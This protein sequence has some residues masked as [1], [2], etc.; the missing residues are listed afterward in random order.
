MMNGLANVSRFESQSTSL[1]RRTFLRIAG[2]GSVALAVFGVA[3]CSGLAQVT[4]T[5][6]GTT[7]STAAAGALAGYEPASVAGW[8]Q[9]PFFEPLASDVCSAYVVA[10]SGRA[11]VVDTGFADTVASITAGLSRLDLGWD[12]V[13]HVIATHFH[14]DH[15]G[16]LFGV[17]EL[18]PKATIYAGQGENSTDPG[19]AVWVGGLPWHRVG[20]GDNVSGLQ[21]VET[22]GHTT[23]H[24]S[25]L[26]P[27]S[28]VLVTGDALNGRDPLKGSIIDPHVGEVAGPDARYTSD[29]ETAVESAKKL[30]QL[31]YDAAL[32]GHGVPILTNASAAVASL[33]KEL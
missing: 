3:G 7:T 8:E 10:R 2:T 15:I 11:V 32:F 19:F 17:L 4:T 16:G 33:A 1:D 14:R 5:L 27:E 28:S 29:M 31:E 13:D 23:G 22:P 9:V 12:A 21:I 18:A 25:V 30:A 20:D 24:I 26:D 6:A